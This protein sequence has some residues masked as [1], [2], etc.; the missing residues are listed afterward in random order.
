MGTLRV[1][2]G[3]LSDK[4][5]VGGLR[6]RTRKNGWDFL[7]ITKSVTGRIGRLL[8][9][10][11]IKIIFRTMKSIQ[12]HLKSTKN[13]RNPQYSDDIYRI[14]CSRRR[15]YI[16]TTK[17]G[18]STRMKQHK[19]KGVIV[20]Y[21][22]LESRPWLNRFWSTAFTTCTEKRSRY[23]SSDLT[24]NAKKKPSYWTKLGTRRYGNLGLRL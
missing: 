18:V 13:A 8:Q 10:H 22:S 11:K 1:R 21:F 7:L 3:A 17:R 2:Y 15:I 23:S 12:R 9:K 19:N 16:G 6:H 24:K 5:D 20:G 14:H 4:V